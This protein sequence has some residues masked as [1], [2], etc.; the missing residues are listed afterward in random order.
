VRLRTTLQLKTFTVASVQ[1]AYEAEIAGLQWSIEP[2]PHSIAPGLAVRVSGYNDTM[3]TLLGELL[4]ALSK[5][6]IKKD[7][8][9]IAKERFLR[10]LRNWRTK[11]PYQWASRLREE[12]MHTGTHND[13]VQFIAARY[14]LGFLCI[15]MIV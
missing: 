6:E 13:V 7:R 2:V 8:F 12:A 11:Q 4:G 15:A 1:V 3:R 5:L 14:Q 10:S 9:D